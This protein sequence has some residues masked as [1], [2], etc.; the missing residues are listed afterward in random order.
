MTTE[1]LYQDFRR[2]Q[3]Q[4]HYSKNVCHMSPRLE[5]DMRRH[6]LEENK[7]LYMRLIYEPRIE[8][9]GRELS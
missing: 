1:E 3:R 7:S 4:Q 8:R 5:S 2:W 6:G 9:E